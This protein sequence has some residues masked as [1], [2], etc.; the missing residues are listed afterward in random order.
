MSDEGRVFCSCGCLIL[1]AGL[2]W[3]MTFLLVVASLW[4]VDYLT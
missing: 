4:V 1:L 2:G 3:V